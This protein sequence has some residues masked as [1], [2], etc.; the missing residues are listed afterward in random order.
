LVAI[1]RVST[2]RSKEIEFAYRPNINIICPIGRK[3]PF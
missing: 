1:V 2:A 3:L